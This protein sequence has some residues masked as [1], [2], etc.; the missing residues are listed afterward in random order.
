[1]TLLE[2]LGLAGFTGGVSFAVWL[3]LEVNKLKV[4]TA[5][6]D[7]QMSP[8]WA[9]VQARISE[10]LHH[11]HPRYF[12]MDRLLEALENMTISVSGRSRLKVLLHE[13][14][15]DM[16]PDITEAQRRSAKAM[17]P[18]MDLVVIEAE[19]ESEG[20]EHK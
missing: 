4:A 11:P 3:T 13:R 16:H 10:D 1:M 17:I 8:L 19:S 2:S 6:L 18:V 20:K 14:S 9:T 12:E 15:V 7:T 5:K